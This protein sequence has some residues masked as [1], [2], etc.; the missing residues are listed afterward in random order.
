MRKALVIIMVIMSL[1][2]AAPAAVN[3]E[4][5]I[6]EEVIEE[7]IIQEETPEEYKWYTDSANEDTWWAEIIR[8]ILSVF[9]KEEKIEIL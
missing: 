3:A 7:E 6:E 8:N 1:I 9:P 4:T 5:I 2:M